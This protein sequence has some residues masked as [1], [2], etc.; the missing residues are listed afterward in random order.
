MEV[1]LSVLTDQDFFFLMADIQSQSLFVREK[2]SGLKA[3][4][5]ID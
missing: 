2:E 5:N 3:Y 4:T 1:I